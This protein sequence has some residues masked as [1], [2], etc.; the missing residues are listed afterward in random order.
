MRPQSKITRKKEIDKLI[1]IGLGQEVLIFLPLSAGAVR[2]VVIILLSFQ[3]ITVIFQL[4]KI[5]P[6]PLTEERNS[7]AEIK[8]RKK[9]HPFNTLLP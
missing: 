8:W 1:V 3:Q 2:V 9:V 4:C 5:L 7:H 6:Q